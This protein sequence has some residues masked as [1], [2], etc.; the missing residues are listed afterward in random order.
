MI[1]PNNSLPLEIRALSIEEDIYQLRFSDVKINEEIDGK[2][3]GADIPDDFPK[4]RI[5]TLDQ[6]RKGRD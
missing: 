2:V 4:P 1:D 5:I 3:F 6:D